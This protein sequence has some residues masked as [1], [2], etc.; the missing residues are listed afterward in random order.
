M[1]QSS[2]E[3]CRGYVEALTAERG[4]GGPHPEYPTVTLSREAGAGALTVAKLAADL[5]D[6]D[7]PGPIP[8]TVFDRNLVERVI[9]DHDL[10]RAVEQFIPEDVPFELTAAVEELLGLHP[11]S[12]SLVQHVSDTIL[13]LAI[14]G[15]A[16]VVG[17]GGNLLTA[18]LPTALHVRLIAPPEFRVNHFCEFYRLSR[19]E[20]AA[21]VAQRDRGRARYVRRHFCAAIADPLQYHMVLNTGQLGFAQSARLIADAVLRMRGDPPAGA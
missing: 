3:A 17:R 21:A 14:A 18:H 7:W 10:P 19:K 8:W 2:F 6:C 12:W 9:E 15:R 16:L 13:R 4:K 20:A 11:D 1:I 5:L